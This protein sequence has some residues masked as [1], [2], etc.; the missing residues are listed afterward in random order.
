MRNWN[1]FSSTSSSENSSVF[2][3][4]MRN[5]NLRGFYSLWSEKMFLACLWGIETDFYLFCI[6]W[7]INRFLA[8]LWGIETIFVIS[9][10]MVKVY[11]FLACLWGIETNQE[12][13]D[14]I[15]LGYVFSV[16][17][18]NWNELLETKKAYQ[19]TVFSVPM[20]NWNEKLKQDLE[21]HERGF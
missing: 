5:W 17:M 14:A 16:P 15:V 7:Y 13:K 18:R 9:K 8:C 20:R 3:V 2:S 12:R 19:Q 11:S 1:V 21:Q 10:R 6:T 4:P